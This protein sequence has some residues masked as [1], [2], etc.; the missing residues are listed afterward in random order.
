MINKTKAPSANASN[1]NMKLLYFFSLEV[2]TMVVLTTKSHLFRK[3][4]MAQEFL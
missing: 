4:E 2:E 1:V 3:F